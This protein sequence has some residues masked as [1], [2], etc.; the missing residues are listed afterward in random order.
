MISIPL[1]LA[2]AIVLLNA[3]YSLNQLSIGF[4]IA[5]GLLVDDSIVVV[6]NIS[7][8]LQ[9]HVTSASGSE[10]PRDRGCP[11][12]TATLILLLCRCCF[13]RTLRQV[14]RSLPIA[15]VYAVLASLLVSLTIIPWLASR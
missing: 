4:V 11:G 12:A 3:T 1:S 8:F 6:E 9:R 5:L 13:C 7:R 2:L 14:H 15:V 10:V